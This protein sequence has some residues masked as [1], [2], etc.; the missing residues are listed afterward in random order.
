[1]DKRGV[2]PSGVFLGSRFQTYGAGGVSGSLYGTWIE[3][4][5]SIA[6]APVIFS[7][8]TIFPPYFFLTGQEG[9]FGAGCPN[10]ESTEENQF[11]VILAMLEQGLL[12]DPLFAISYQGAEMAEV[13]LGGVES[14]AFTGDLKVAP[15]PPNKDSHWQ[16]VPD[17]IWLASDPTSAALGP[18]TVIPGAAGAV[19]DSGFAALAIADDVMY[20]TWLGKVAE[21]VGNSG[22]EY[23]MQA[24]LGKFPA[25]VMPCNITSQMPSLGFTLQGVNFTVDGEDQALPYE[26]VKLYSNPSL[27]EAP[28]GMCFLQVIHFPELPG[29][30]KMLFGVPF[31]RKY[32]TVFNVLDKSS[33]GCSLGFAARAP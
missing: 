25:P 7:N 6:V 30:L 2:R 14:S 18:Q 24:I 13:V 32:Y 31:L 9:I 29:D 21:A 1:V 33:N 11:N 22:N 4:G 27:P 17:A 26:D 16:F 28:P 20:Q 12:A 8:V 5:D 10:V 3:I 15:V 19:I 23:T